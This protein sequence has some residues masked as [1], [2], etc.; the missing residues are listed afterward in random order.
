VAP[1]TVTIYPMGGG[2]LAR[3]SQYNEGR[4]RQ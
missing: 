1:I 2:K 3:L 4:D